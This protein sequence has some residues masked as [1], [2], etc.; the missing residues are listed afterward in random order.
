MADGRRKED[1]SHTELVINIFGRLEAIDERTKT[2]ASQI[3]TI[4]RKL[5]RLTEPGDCMQGERNSAA[6]R[7]LTWV[8]GLITTAVFSVITYFHIV[9]RMP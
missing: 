3:D 1:M 8:G 4:F 7:A 2:Q 9:K 6:I 5:N